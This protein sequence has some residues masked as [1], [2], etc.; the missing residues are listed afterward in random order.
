MSKAPNC[1]LTGRGRGGDFAEESEGFCCYAVALYS[2]LLPP[3]CTPKCPVLTFMSLPAGAAF[4]PPHARSAAPA[5]ILRKP[6]GG[7][8]EGEAVIE[9]R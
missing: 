5:A 1:S 8:G 4:L 9:G 3:F 6:V 2:S 7:E